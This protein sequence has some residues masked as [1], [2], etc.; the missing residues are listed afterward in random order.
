MNYICK[1]EIMR[2]NKISH[3]HTH[4]FLIAYFYYPILTYSVSQKKCLFFM[5]NVF[6]LNLV[7]HSTQKP[8]GQI[9]QNTNK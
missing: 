3:F 6:P 2:V 5:V 9:L 8:G 1:I 4:K 7:K